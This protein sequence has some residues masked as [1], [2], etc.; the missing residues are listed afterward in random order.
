MIYF[1]SDT[2]FNH[3]K[4]F[5]WKDRGYGSVDEMNEDIIKKW[6]EVVTPGDD[7]YHLGDVMLGDNEK[8]LYMLNRLNGRIH[9]VL[10]NHDTETR[11]VLYEGSWNV[12]EIAYADMIKYG[13]NHLYLSH[14]PT[15]IGQFDAHKHHGLI[16]LCGHT[17]QTEPFVPEWHNPY[18]YNVGMDAHDM[19]PVGLDEIMMDISREREKELLLSPE[20]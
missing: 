17:H 2:H 1:T 14:Y 18:I 19:R 3:D 10:G 20:R 15:L 8:G 13:K 9:I 5:I 16:N 12:C 4:E 11:R 7:V 6:N